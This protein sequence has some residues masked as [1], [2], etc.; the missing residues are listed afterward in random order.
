MKTKTIFTLLFS[1]SI[2]FGSYALELTTVP[3][4]IKLPDTIED[5]RIPSTTNYAT[6]VWL[7]GGGLAGGKPHFPFSRDEKI[8][9]VAVKY[10]LLG[11]DAKSG[12]DCI[13]D[14]ADDIGKLLT[15]FPE[16]LEEL[17]RYKK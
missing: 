13:E 9:Q 3:E 12:V 11:K 7:H 6:L 1:F 2:I 8:A 5:I 16:I 10:R 4:N 14:A 15:K 17:K